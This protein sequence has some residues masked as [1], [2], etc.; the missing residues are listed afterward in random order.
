MAGRRE[1]LSPSG[2]PPGAEPVLAGAWDALEQATDPELGVS[3]VAMGLIRKL[4]VEGG[5]ASVELTFTSM[6]CPWMDWIQD[7]IRTALLEAPGIEGVDIE[8]VWDRP[9][10]RHDL[11]ED[12]RIRLV[13]SGISL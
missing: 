12:A 2:G 8:I 7:S 13:A 6:G 4:T 1:R 9:W 10:S 5:R 3:L 11:R